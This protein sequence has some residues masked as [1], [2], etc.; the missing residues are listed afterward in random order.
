MFKMVQPGC[1]SSPTCTIYIDSNYSRTIS[2]ES[3][4]KLRMHCF[5]FNVLTC[6][7]LTCA[8]INGLGSVVKSV[9]KIGLMQLGSV[10]LNS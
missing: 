6:N 2:S 4:F 10:V 7:M 1:A 9:Y 5:Q 3:A 8:E